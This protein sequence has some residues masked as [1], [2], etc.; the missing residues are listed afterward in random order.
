MPKAKFAIRNGEPMSSTNTEHTHD[1]RHTHNMHPSINQSTCFA[2]RPFESRTRRLDVNFL[3]ISQSASAFEY[4][5]ARCLCNRHEIQTYLDAHQTDFEAQN[6]HF[7][8]KLKMRLS[9]NFCSAH[10]V[11]VK[12]FKL[13]LRIRSRTTE[14]RASIRVYCTRTQHGSWRSWEHLNTTKDDSWKYFFLPMA[15]YSL[16]NSTCINPYEMMLKRRSTKKKKKSSVFL[17]TMAAERTGERKKKNRK[18]GKFTLHV[19]RAQSEQ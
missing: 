5:C 15:T 12:Q 4:V 19:H 17:V 16:A 10:K 13:R 11:Y 8:S 14:H 9:V 18:S 7:C 3:Q 6:R 2:M 1:T